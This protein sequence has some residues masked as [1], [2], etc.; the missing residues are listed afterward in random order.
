MDTDQAVPALKNNL[1]ATMVLEY[2]AT[3]LLKSYSRQVRRHAQSKIKR[4]AKFMEKSGVIIPLVVDKDNF[5]IL[6]NARLTALILL[7]VESVP[8]IRV[9]HLDEGMIRALILADNQFTLNADWYKQALREELLY[10]EPRMLEI[11]LELIDLGFETGQLDITIGDLELD[12]PADETPV[13]SDQPPVTQTG[14]V[15]HLG[16]H[17]LI[18]GDARDEKTYQSLMGDELADMAFG[19]LPYNVKIDGHVCGNGSIQH[20]EFAMAS[21]EMTP[22]EFIA[23]MAMIFS[24]LRKFSKGGSVHMQCMDW[25]HSLELLTAAQQADYSYLNMAV[26]VKHTGGM[27]SLYRSQHELVH[28]FKS[29]TAAHINNVRLGKFGRNRTNVWQYEGANSLRAERKGD[30]ALHST[31]KP[32]DMVADAIKD[33]SARGGIILD[34]TAGAGSTLI[35]ADRT[36]RIARLIELD[37]AYC[38]VIVKRWQNLTG[39]KAV[40]GATGQAFDDMLAQ[41]DLNS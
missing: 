17:K 18:C 31:T 9:S 37:A 10:L 30:L 22:A 21:G 39:K 33:C 6:G 13:P 11:G 24:H 14:Y 8:V 35:A 15:W 29:G 5:V 19:D 7:G 12:A 27:G 38:D 32:V 34:P 1:F 26:W 3:G 2:V 28:V 4:L 23:F 36:G 16:A 40:L 20:R 25:R 41:M